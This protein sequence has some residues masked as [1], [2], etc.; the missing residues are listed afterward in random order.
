MGAEKHDF[1]EGNHEYRLPRYLQEKAPELADLDELTIPNLLQL[2]GGGWNYVPYREFHKVGKL[3]VTHETGKAGATAHVSAMNDFQDN[4]VIGHTHRMGVSYAGNAKGHPHVGAMFGWLG[5]K[6]KVDYMHKIKANRDWMLGFG[7]GYL[8][9]NGIIHL[10]AV[11]I[12]NYKVV[13]E[14][15]LVTA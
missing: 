7:V 12:I 11:P 13:V 3:H 15:K 1:V 14:G 6:S 10:Q 9:P 4:V 2:D 8:E 5:D